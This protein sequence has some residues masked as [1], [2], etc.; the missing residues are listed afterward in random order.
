MPAASNKKSWRRVL[1]MIHGTLV[2]NWPRPHMQNDNMRRTLEKCEDAYASLGKARTSLDKSVV[3]HLLHIFAGVF[4]N[5]CFQRA[6]II[7][8]GCSSRKH[9]MLLG[10]PR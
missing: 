1:S 3:A 5:T 4:A 7:Q 10:T 9:N 2:F 6:S 8:R